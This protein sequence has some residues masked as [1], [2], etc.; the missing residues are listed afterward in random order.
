LT[1]EQSEDGDSGSE[2]DDDQ[3]SDGVFE[4]IGTHGHPFWSAERQQW[5]A[6]GELRSGETLLLVGGQLAEVVERWVERPLKG[7]TFTT[8]NF[9]V[10]DWHTYHVAPIH[11]IT[12]TLAVW[13]HNASKCSVV[14]QIVDR[15]PAGSY[16][17]R[18]LRRF[19]KAWNEEIHKAGG[20]MVRRSLTAAEELA[21]LAWKRAMRKAFPSRF[22]DKVVGHTPDAA[23]G[24]PVAGGKAMALDP[25]VNASIGGQ[26][27]KKPLGYKYGRV[28]VIRE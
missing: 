17:S 28:E 14:W 22:Q 9:T 12:H 10:E 25:T 11:S 6:M 26:V 24:G 8:Y 23:A 21:S 19:V 1:G 7:A 27:G 4:V 15:F 3:G 2:G 5:V 18:Q 13:V 20:S 16:E